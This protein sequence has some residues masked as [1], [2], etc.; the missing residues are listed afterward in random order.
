[1]QTGTTYRNSKS[2]QR[3]YLGIRPW[4]LV[5]WMMTPLG[6]STFTYWLVF[7]GLPSL[8]NDA[9]R[10]EK[11]PCCSWPNVGPLGR[12][13][14]LFVLIMC[15]VCDET[16]KKT[17]KANCHVKKECSVTGLLGSAFCIQLNVISQSTG[18]SC[19]GLTAAGRAEKELGES[20]VTE[21]G[22][23]WGISLLSSFFPF[24]PYLRLESQFA[25]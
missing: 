14:W 9:I 23:G 15:P 8:G 12:E 17:T 22:M 5:S 2:H 4:F 16:G 3:S 10:L 7:S 11:S 13:W 24:S 18:S 1:M 19:K 25:G 20:E 21:R 6:Y